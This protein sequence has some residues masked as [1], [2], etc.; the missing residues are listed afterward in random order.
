MLLSRGVSH[1]TGFMSVIHIYFVHKYATY[2]SVHKM[3]SYG[4]TDIECISI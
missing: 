3:E 1:R 4:M 2:N